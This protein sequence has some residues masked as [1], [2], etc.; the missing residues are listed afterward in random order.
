MGVKCS[1]RRATSNRF[2][3]PAPEANGNTDDHIKQRTDSLGK[4][5]LPGDLILERVKEFGQE[6]QGLQVTTVNDGKSKISF[7]QFVAFL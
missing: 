1:T 5:P 6:M 7:L 2:D 3:S 4:F